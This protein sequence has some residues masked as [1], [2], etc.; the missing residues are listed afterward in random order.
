MSNTEQAKVLVE[1]KNIGK[2]FPGVRANDGVNLTIRAGEI[3]AL[4]GENGAGK[5]TLMSI[6]TG[7]YRADEGELFV[8]GSKVNFV[9]PRDAINTGIG[10]VHQHF[11]LVSSFSVSE[12]V[13]MGLDTGSPLLKLDEIEKKLAVFSEEYGLK[14]DPRAKIWQLSIGEQQRVEIIKL[15][16]R[17]ADI[18]IL[19]EHTAVLTPQEAGD[20]YNILRQLVNEGKGVIVI[21]HKMQEVMEHADVVTV[22]RN[23][24]AVASVARVD[25]TE[26]ELARMMVGRDLEQVQGASA[27]EPGDVILKLTGVNVPGDRGN[28]ALKNIDLEI[29]AGEILGIAGVAGNGQRELAEAITGLRP[30]ISGQ[31]LIYGQDLTNKSTGEIIRAGVA[32]IPEDR[33]GT[34]LVANLDARENVLLKHYQAEEFRSG[35]FIKWKSLNQYTEKLVE[36]FDV[37]LAGLEVPVKAMSGGNMQRLLLA[38]EISTGPSLIVAVYPVRGLDIGAIN[39]IHTLLLEARSEGR[40][41]LLISEE[42]EELF[43][44]SDKLAVLHEGEIMGIRS[45][46]ETNIEEV[47]LMMAGQN[48]KTGKMVNSGCAL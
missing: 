23:G 39:A 43:F 31:V 17:G 45:V 26:A 4:L 3:H 20:L 48:M 47:G 9:S 12:N 29:R 46:Q 24:K 28:L 37:K 8:H 14:I 10:M 6:L 41:V 36:D 7:L 11:K 35:P 32:H 38:R 13:A 22:M 18:L 2:S 15:L 1:M 5:S 42:L 19:D 44:L 21:T 27:H 40:A 16:Y 34:G 30:V 25:T 33:C